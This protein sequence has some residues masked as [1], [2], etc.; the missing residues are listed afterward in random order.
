MYHHKFRF[1]FRVSYSPRNCRFGFNRCICA[2]ETWWN[3]SVGCV[4]APGLNKSYAPV[5]PQTVP[6]FIMN[7]VL[8]F[9]FVSTCRRAELSTWLDR[10]TSNNELCRVKRTQARNALLIALLQTIISVKKKFI[11]FSQTLVSFWIRIFL[12]YILNLNFFQ[13]KIVIY[14]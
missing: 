14:L 13:A 5:C 11:W 9:F 1:A 6:C 12:V 3:A 2:D 8:N 4:F 7:L 10:N